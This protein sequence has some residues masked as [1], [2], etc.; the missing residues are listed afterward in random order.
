MLN[1]AEEHHPEVQELMHLVH[2]FLHLQEVQV[3]DSS[4]EVHL[5][6]EQGMLAIRAEAEELRALM[7]LES[8]TSDL[9]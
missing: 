8:L 3:K 5:Q 9:I 1:P 6:V 4:Q 2:R 7:R